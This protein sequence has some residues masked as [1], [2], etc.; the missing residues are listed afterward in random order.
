M[1]RGSS[2]LIS[3]LLGL[4]VSYIIM[5]SIGVLAFGHTGTNPS[6]SV[7]SQKS[8]SFYWPCQFL[9]RPCLCACHFV[10]SGVQKSDLRTPLSMCGARLEGAR[11]I[12][13]MIFYC[14]QSYCSI[15]EL[16][17]TATNMTKYTVPVLNITSS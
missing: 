9:F 14:Y 2:G 10:Y 7:G 11:L 6:V 13:S 1:C 12:I 4:V 3:K 15:S 5:S 8:L 16:I 17:Y